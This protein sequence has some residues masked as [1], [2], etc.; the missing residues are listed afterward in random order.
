MIIHSPNKTRNQN[1]VGNWGNLVKEKLQ[2]IG[3]HSGNKILDVG[4]FSGEYVFYL[5]K[6]GYDAYGCDIKENLSWKKNISKFQIGSLYSLPYNNKSFDTIL[7][8]EVLE[9]LEALRIALRELKRVSRKNVIISVP[10]CELPPI[11]NLSGLSFYHNID[12]SHIN[13][14]TEK[15]L[16]E[17]LLQE[18]FKIDLVTKISPIKPI[19]LLLHTLYFPVFLT[20]FIAKIFNRLPSRKLYSDIVIVASIVN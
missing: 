5:N 13:R 15:D 14:F 8:F 6:K 16:V 3:G 1:I 9:H 2:I 12:K 10:N 7:V 17:L 19:I 20:N 11:F 4:C 18:D